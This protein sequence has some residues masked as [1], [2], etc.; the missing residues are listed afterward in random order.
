MINW[1][2]AVSGMIFAFLWF[3]WSTKSWANLL[4]KFVLFAMTA[5]SIFLTLQSLGYIVKN[6][7]G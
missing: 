3:I 2:L 4:V 1:Y 5:W 7:L 6:P